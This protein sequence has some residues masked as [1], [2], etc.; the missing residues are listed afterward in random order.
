MT[1]QAAYSILPCFFM[2]SL[3]ADMIR[4]ISILLYSILLVF[5]TCMYHDT[6]FRE[7]KV[8]NSNEKLR[9]KALFI[10]VVTRTRFHKTGKLFCKCRAQSNCTW[11]TVWL[12]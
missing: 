5:F 6:R 11:W 3:V 8:R 2:R 10:A 7:C 12:L 9:C 4:L 1:V